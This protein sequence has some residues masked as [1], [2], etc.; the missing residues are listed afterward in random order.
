MSHQHRF[1]Q[2]SNG[3]P[4]RGQ[5]SKPRRPAPRPSAGDLQ[6]IHAQPS[7]R[8]E[9]GVQYITEEEYVKLLENQKQYEASVGQGAYHG[10]YNIYYR[11]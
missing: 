10:N 11:K 6:Y 8:P 3:S 5:S 2:H 4:D 1:Q 9:Q 7:N